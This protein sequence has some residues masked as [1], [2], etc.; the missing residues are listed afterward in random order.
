MGE[1]IMLVK[2]KRVRILAVNYMYQNGER[3]PYIRLQGKWLGKI[4]FQCGD[5][6]EVEQ[7]IG[8]LFIKT[9]SADCCAEDN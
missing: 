5:K 6:I 8:Y 4:G 3:I 9:I 1:Y 2:E 7:K